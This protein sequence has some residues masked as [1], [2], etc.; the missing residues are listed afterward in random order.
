MSERVLVTGGGG[1]LGGALVD[2]L[3]ERGP[4]VRS[5]A[6]GH[7]PAL[8][9]KGVEALRGDLADPQAVLDAVADC[10][11][12]F[13]VA[14]KAGIWGRPE[15]FHSANVVGTQ[16]VIAACR[17][18]GIGRLIHTSTPS[19]V[20]HGGAIEGGDESLPYADPPLTPYGH[21]KALAEAA[22]LAANDANLSTVALRPRLIWGP[23]DTQVLPRMVARSRAGRL[24]QVGDVDPLIDTIYIDNAVDSHLLAFDRLG[25]G[26]DTD[27]CAGKAYFITQGEPIGLYAMLN[28]ML[29]AV[30]EPPVTR[31]VPRWVATAAG[32]TFEPIWRL[33]GRDDDPPMTRFLAIQLSTA[34]WFDISAARRD[35]GFEPK[36]DTAEG[37]R[38]LAAWWRESGGEAD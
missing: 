14:A 38:R 31:K 30:G 4:Q 26:S 16:N 34:N 24:R 17:S 13:H 3:L 10:T 20:Q 36:V 19:V 8:T 11:A 25:A 6:R 7:Y 18:H 5:L 37:L 35:L 32:A 21:T 15:D 12:V 9:D 1:F 23:R 22:V 28:G 33:L 29:Q 2:A 27:A